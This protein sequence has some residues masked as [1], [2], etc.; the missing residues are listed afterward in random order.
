MRF[1]FKYADKTSKFIR[2]FWVVNSVNQKKKVPVVKFG[3]QQIRQYW[4]G[5]FYW[6]TSWDL[7]WADNSYELPREEQC[8]CFPDLSSYSW[9]FGIYFVL[10]YLYHFWFWWV[11]FMLPIVLNNFAVF[12]YKHG[13]P[14]CFFLIFFLLPKN[15]SYLN[16]A[17]GFCT[18][19]FNTIFFSSVRKAWV[20]L[21]Q[22]WNHPRPCWH[23][24]FI[25]DNA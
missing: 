14:F 20:I 18:C 9:F 5:I 6:R 19:V 15:A 21:L 13:V 8:I 22:T 17:V 23:V 12:F 16:L 10:F 4:T 2:L 11:S 1:P 24:S 3:K 7:Q 25:L